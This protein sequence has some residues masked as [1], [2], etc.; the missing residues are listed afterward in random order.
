M[1]RESVGKVYRESPGRDA[2]RPRNA[3]N[4]VGGC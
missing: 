2:A 4:P 1:K 3:T